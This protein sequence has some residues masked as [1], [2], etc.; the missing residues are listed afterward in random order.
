[1]PTAGT[2]PTC[3]GRE[4]RHHRRRHHPVAERAHPLSAATGRQHRVPW[5]R[6]SRRAPPR[7]AAAGRYRWPAG[8]DRGRRQRGRDRR[9]RRRQRLPAT[10]HR[11]VSP[12]RQREPCHRLNDPVTA[13]RL[14][15]AAWRVFP[16][17]QAR[18][19]MA[20]CW[21]SSSKTASCPV[22]H[23]S[24]RNG[25]AFSPD[26]K[27]LAAP[28]ATASVRLWNPA[29]GQAV[30]APPR[31]SARTA[32]RRKA[33]TGW[34]SA[35]TASCW[36]P[37]TPTAPCGC[38]TRPPASRSAPRSRPRRTHR[39]GGCS[40]VAFSPDGKLLATADY[41]GTVRLWNP[42]T[43]RPVGALMPAVTKANERDRGGVQP[44]RQAA[45]QRRQRRLRKVV[46]PGHRPPG[47]YPHP[48]HRRRGGR[49]RGG[50]QPGRQ[51]AGQRGLD[52]TVRLW[53][54]VTGQQV[55]TPLPAD[56]DARRRRVGVAF[57]PDGRL[58]A[59]A[60]ADGT[61]RLWD[62]ATGQGSARRCRPIP[63]P[64]ACGVAF[65]P[66]GKL[67]AS[68]DADGTVRLWNPVTGRAPVL[69][70]RPTSA[71]R[72]RVR[73]GHAQGGVQS[74]QQAAGQRRRATAPCDCGTRPPG[75]RSDTLPAAGPARRPASRGWRSA[76]TAS[77]WPAPTTTAPCGS[78]TRPPRRRLASPP[79]Q[80]HYGTA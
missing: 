66:D 8:P 14:A 11:P 21:S 67:L 49:D 1:M 62:P 71:R 60:D 69:P 64:A 32:V 27:L 42:A 13:R 20:P 45:G 53:N 34:R 61:V 51:A 56:P 73:G 36:P 7:P 80:R 65:S 48:G 63:A 37:P 9:A 54:P 43:G 22:I 46:E 75:S 41:D 5:R 58:L 24:R 76:R 68:A 44:G 40:G 38:G 78:G 79:G 23:P 6:A 30:G 16:T 72:R 19:A 33:C 10:C 29:T 55:G 70:C 47:R 74:G 26:G 57:S 25:V 50:V 12:A 4:A 2:P 28:T 17:D 52:G 3:T 39:A 59:T 18:S 77:C 31:R 35:R 15:V